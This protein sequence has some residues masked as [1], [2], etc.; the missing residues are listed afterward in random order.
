MTLFTTWILVNDFCDGKTETENKKK[1]KK[2]EEEEEEE[3]LPGPT[4]PRQCCEFQSKEISDDSS[5][6]ITLRRGSRKK[7]E[8]KGS[9][10]KPNFFCSHLLQ[11]GFFEQPKPDLE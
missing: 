7:A 1:K 8:G 10:D 5:P 9:R 11:D 6:R 2:R 4:L 3:F